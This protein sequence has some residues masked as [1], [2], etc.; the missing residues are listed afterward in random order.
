MQPLWSFF[1]SYKQNLLFDKIILGLQKDKYYKL[2]SF[3][4]S[5]FWFFVLFPE[6]NL[7]IL[8]NLKAAG[9]LSR[10]LYILNITILLFFFSFQNAIFWRR[11]A[12]G[13]SKNLS[14]IG[15][16]IIACKGSYIR[17][18]KVCIFQKFSGT[19]EP[20][21]TP[22][23][24]AFEAFPFQFKYIVLFSHEVILSPHIFFP[25]ILLYTFW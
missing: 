19:K 20:Y 10:R 5:L 24:F 14:K 18:V 25:P 15:R 17:N 7:F 23:V 1:S 8:P 16:I 4:I 6:Q 13:F 12:A 9:L 3:L 11:H 22:A 2:F 21:F